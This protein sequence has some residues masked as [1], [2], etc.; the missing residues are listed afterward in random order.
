MISVLK[1][2]IQ[3]KTEENVLNLF[4]IST[5]RHF[6]T[7]PETLVSIIKLSPSLRIRE[8]TGSSAVLLYDKFLAGLS[9]PLRCACKVL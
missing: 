1:L 4:E 2:K 9:A 6:G 5:N 7:L 8:T 3:S